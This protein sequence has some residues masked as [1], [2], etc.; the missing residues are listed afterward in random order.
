MDE[1]LL[2][3]MLLGIVLI[4]GVSARIRNTILTLPMLYHEGIFK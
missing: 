4:A 3:T 2:L 1:L